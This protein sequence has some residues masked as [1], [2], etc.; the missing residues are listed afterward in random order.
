M[1]LGLHRQVQSLATDGTILEANVIRFTP[2]PTTA[3]STLTSS[4]VAKIRTPINAFGGDAAKTDIMLSFWVYPRAMT[5]DASSTIHT[6]YHCWNEQDQIDLG[7]NFMYFCRITGQKLHFKFFR[8][9]LEHS[10]DTI[11]YGQWNHIMVS[12][13]LSAN[14]ISASGGTHRDDKFHLVVNGTIYNYYISGGTLTNDF[15]S[16]YTIG[17]S[18]S[19][20]SSDNTQPFTWGA[21]STTADMSGGSA[22]G[23][24]INY[25]NGELFQFY[26]DNEYYDLTQA[27]ERVKFYDSGSH[28]PY[29]G[30]P[31]GSSDPAP[32]VKIT[33]DGVFNRGSN[34]NINTSLARTN[35]AVSALSKP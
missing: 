4:N 16:D 9:E 33:E 26:M 20:L 30:L 29:E 17:N 25:Y 14:D 19:L 28:I 22:P 24:Y 11:T 6:I 23:N 7:D 13:N 27:S 12:A 2:N 21:E 10:V 8:R 1:A 15:G 31:T 3:G 32:L 34:T 35:V 18:D 5:S